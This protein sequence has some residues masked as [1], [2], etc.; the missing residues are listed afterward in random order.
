MARDGAYS[1][2]SSPD[3]FVGLGGEGSDP[4]LEIGELDSSAPIPC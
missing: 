2:F 4:T 3:P 1:L